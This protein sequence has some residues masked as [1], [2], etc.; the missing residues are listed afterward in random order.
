[1]DRNNEHQSKHI[2]TFSYSIYRV[3]TAY[4]Y[5]TPWTATPPHNSHHKS[6]THK[7]HNLLFNDHWAPLMSQHIPPDWFPSPHGSNL[8]S[9]RAHIY[10]C[11]P[12]YKH[13]INSSLLYSPGTQR[14]LGMNRSLK[15]TLGPGVKPQN[16]RT[17]RDWRLHLLHKKTND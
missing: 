11:S 15:G 13:I 10:K 12:M 16:S 6:E 14:S 4:K 7:D 5:S 9:T 17:K 3:R 1:M 8:N 2:T